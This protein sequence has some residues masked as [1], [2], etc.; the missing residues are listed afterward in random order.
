MQAPTLLKYIFMLWDI[1]RDVPRLRYGRVYTKMVAMHDNAE[2][3]KHHKRQQKTT[4]TTN[5][6]K[7]EVTISKEE[8]PD[9]TIL[10]SRAVKTT[11][12]TTTVSTKKYGH[13]IYNYDS[14]YLSFCSTLANCLGV[15]RKR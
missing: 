15:V 14:H 13:R 9:G 5:E 3:N 6:P 1:P 10:I 7:K 4:H 12:A 8:Q 11:V 2:N